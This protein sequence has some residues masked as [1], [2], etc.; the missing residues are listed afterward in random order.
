MVEKRGRGE[1][2]KERKKVILKEKTETR[3]EG[4]FRSKLRTF[5]ESFH[6]STFDLFDNSNFIEIFL[7]LGLV[8]IPTSV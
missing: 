8:L 6:F 5:L 3:L 4:T 7:V 2:K 1:R